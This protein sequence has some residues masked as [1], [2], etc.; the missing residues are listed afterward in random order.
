[1][2]DL[3]KL[4]IDAHKGNVE[5]YSFRE[6]QETLRQALIE[7][8]GG[9]T[10]IDYRAIRDGKCNGVFSLV[11][12]IIKNTV[13][14]GIQS[15]P[16]F[17]ALVEYKNVA[18][19]DA[20]V[21]DVYDDTLFYID[22]VARGTQ[23]IRRQRLGGV[24]Q[25][26]IPV[27][28]HAIRIYEELDRI[29]SG[30]ADFNEMIDKVAKSEENMIMNEVYDLFANATSADFGG[31]YIIPNVGSAAGSYNETTL[32]EIIEH[33]EAAAGGKTANVIGTKAGLRNLMNGITAPAEVAK[34]DMYNDGYI[35]KF[36][37]SNVIAIPQRHKIGSTNFVYNDKMIAILASSDKPIKLVREGEP[38]II[39]RDPAL[40]MDLTQE[41]FMAEKWGTGIVMNGNSGIGK[42]T[43]A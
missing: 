41:Y 43:I 26:T 5:K 37:G 20:P 15:N 25:I 16:I 14:E 4:A 1:M 42:Y 32:L 31:V 27:N 19:G 28:V 9:S 21:F 8:N 23:A 10:K 7:A 36:Y 38:L 22:K 13:E 30:R 33:V 11:E 6:A 18:E 17:D 35:G 39:P 3:V 34:E 29:L 24:N 2:N 40:N 12:E